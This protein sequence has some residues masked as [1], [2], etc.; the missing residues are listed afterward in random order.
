MRQVISCF[1]VLA[2]LTIWCGWRYT[3]PRGVKASMSVGAFAGL[4]TGSTTLGGPPVAL[5]MLS[6]PYTAD[7][8]RASLI[9]VFATIQVSSV[10]SLAVAG[11]IN[12]ETLWRV[13]VATPVFLCGLWIGGLLF[14]RVDERLY[15]RGILSF[16][17][18]VSTA[19]LIF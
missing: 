4:I 13:A 19:I 11:L 12:E 16:M 2:A 14:S 3:G 18:V 5:Y 9:G 7:V 10:S 15:R 8:V 6:G 17:I 1:V